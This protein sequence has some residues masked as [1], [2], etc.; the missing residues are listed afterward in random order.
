MPT[1]PRKGMDHGH[2][3]YSPIPTRP[4]LEWPGGA[5]LALWVVLYLEYWEI[6]PPEDAYRDPRYAA[7]FGS[8]FPDYRTH[9]IREY[10]NRVGIFRVLE[11]LDRYRVPVTVAANAEACA[12]YPYLMEAFAHRGWEVMAHGTHATRMITSR[13]SE[14]EERAYI[15][16][17]AAAVERATGQRPAGWMSQDFG[18]SPRT[19][20]LVAEAGFRY[21]ADWPNDDQPYPMTLDRPLVSLPYH[22]EWDDVLLLWFRQVATPRYPDI[23]GDAFDRLLE[24]GKTTGRMMSLGVHPWLLGQPHRIRYLDEA[25]AKIAGHQGLWKATGGEICEAFLKQQ[26]APEPPA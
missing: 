8:F 13:M 5:G 25:L 1:Q 16:E 15:E 6:N 12:R 17:S 3:R 23:V 2:Y 22:V 21:M 7:P 20:D 10:G 4:R 26:P 24:E 9:S 14:E 18:Q 19:P 11:V